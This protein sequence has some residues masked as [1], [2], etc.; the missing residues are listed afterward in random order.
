LSGPP[1]QPKAPG[2]AGGYLLWAPGLS[3][4]ACDPAGGTR[5][6]GEGL[7]PGPSGGGATRWP[8]SARVA[9]APPGQGRQSPRLAS[10][11]V[12]RT[13]AS[14]TARVSEQRRARRHPP[15]RTLDADRDRP[16]VLELCWKRR[17]TAAKDDK[18]PWPRIPLSL[19]NVCSWSSSV[20]DYAPPVPAF[21]FQ[22]AWSSGTVAGRAAGR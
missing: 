20:A 5:G 8:Q 18:E 11:S 7:P 3:A 17:Q 10:G 1:V 12:R 9:Y 19:V 14:M 16:I 2:S 4:P 21:N 15:P 22:W 13:W 6:A